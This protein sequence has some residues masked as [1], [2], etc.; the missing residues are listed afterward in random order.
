MIYVYYKKY[1]EFNLLV[2]IHVR[3][4]PV[5]LKNTVRMRHSSSKLPSDVASMTARVV[6]LLLKLCRFISIVK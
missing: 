2:E 6:L 4:P 3:I 1:V 5:T